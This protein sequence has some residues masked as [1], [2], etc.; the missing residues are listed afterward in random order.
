M[1]E[2]YG[3][4]LAGQAYRVDAGTADSLVSMGLADVVISRKKRGK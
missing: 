3:R 4:L 1:R 2:T